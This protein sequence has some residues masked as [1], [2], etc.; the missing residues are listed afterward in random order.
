[1]KEVTVTPDDEIPKDHDIIES[2]S[3][4]DDLLQ[5]KSSLGERTYSRCREVW[6]PRMNH[7]TKKET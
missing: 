3:P 7:E 5:E 6:C 1:V 2:T 4:Y